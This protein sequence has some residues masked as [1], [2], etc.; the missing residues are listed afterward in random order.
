M[1]KREEVVEVAAELVDRI[2]DDARYVDANSAPGGG[3]TIDVEPDPHPA[4]TA[5]AAVIEATVRSFFGSR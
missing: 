4:D 3:V 1:S 2:P 5:T